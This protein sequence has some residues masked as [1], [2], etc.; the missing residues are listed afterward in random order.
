MAAGSGSSYVVARLDKA[1]YS[2]SDSEHFELKR[3]QEKFFMKLN[4][5]LVFK[6]C[7]KACEMYLKSNIVKYMFFGGI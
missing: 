1:H 7:Y 5:S 3:R 6:V 2:A 4:Q